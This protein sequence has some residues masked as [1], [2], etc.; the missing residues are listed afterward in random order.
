MERPELRCETRSRSSIDQ[1]LPGSADTSSR[2]LRSG[3]FTRT[4]GKVDVSFECGRSD[5]R[6][7]RR[8][9]M[10]GEEL[11]RTR[12][13]RASGVIPLPARPNS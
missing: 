9:G 11:T 5:A 2:A 1:A 6:E 13:D 3:R 7:E 4:T 12:D 10:P 8:L